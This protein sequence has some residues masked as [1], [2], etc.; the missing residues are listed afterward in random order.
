MMPVKPLIRVTDG[1]K[2]DEKER[3]GACVVGIFEAYTPEGDVKVF[4][5]APNL[6]DCAFLRD[7]A[8]AVERVDQHHKAILSIKSEVEGKE[9]VKGGCV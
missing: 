5:F 3:Y 9:Y 4:H 8:D 6:E 2:K 1:W 7:L